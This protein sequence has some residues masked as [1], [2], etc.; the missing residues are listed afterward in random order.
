MAPLDHALPVALED[1]SITDPPLQNVVALPAV[2]VGAG[3]VGLTV[4]VVAADVDEH[5]A[6][7]V[8][9]TV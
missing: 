9:C 1:V 2:I 7:L 4:T 5:P 6:A 3:G 8:V